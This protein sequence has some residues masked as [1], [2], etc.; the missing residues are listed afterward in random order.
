MRRELMNLLETLIDLFGKENAVIIFD[1]LIETFKS[2]HA[3]L[4]RL[5]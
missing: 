3:F 1:K 4:K 2:D 5:Q